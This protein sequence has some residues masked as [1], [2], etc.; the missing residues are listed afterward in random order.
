MI[1]NPKRGI[2]VASMWIID[3]SYRDRG[4]DLSVKEG[5]T[6]SKV[7]HDY[8][9]YILLHVDDPDSIMRGSR[10]WR[11]STMLRYALSDP[12]SKNFLNIWYTPEGRLIRA[13]NSQGGFGK[14]EWAVSK[15]TA[16]VGLLKMR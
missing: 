3:S 10:L 6:V 4:I 11:N 8:N 16:E 13:V 1:L 7:H 2:E 5:N 12:S 15:N 14:R 9:P